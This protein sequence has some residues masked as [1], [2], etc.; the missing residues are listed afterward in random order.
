MQDSLPFKSL[1]SPWLPPFSFIHT[2]GPPHGLA[3]SAPSPF[4]TPTR[5]SSTYTTKCWH[6][7]LESATN[8]MLS[9]GL[10]KKVEEMSLGSNVWGFR[11]IDISSHSRRIF[12]RQGL[13]GICSPS[14]R[15]GKRG[16]E[17]VKSGRVWLN[18]APSPQVQVHCSSTGSGSAH[19]R[20]GMFPRNTCQWS[21]R[22]ISTLV[23]SSPSSH[24][25]CE[26][27]RKSN[28]DCA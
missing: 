18:F 17:P 1:N 16:I 23:G 24:I 3:S 22:S 21:K 12:P 25:A 19:V 2:S 10:S 4:V 11:G 7:W 27:E 15:S 20:V 14:A 8:K 9:S 28:G 26:P 5:L 13:P 6:L